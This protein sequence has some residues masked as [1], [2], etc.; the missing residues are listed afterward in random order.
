[1]KLQWL[2]RYKLVV[3]LCVIFL[4]ALALVEGAVPVYPGPEAGPAGI[5]GAATSERPRLF[6]PG[7]SVTVYANKLTSVETVLPYPYF[8][9][10]FCRPEKID[11]AQVFPGEQLLGTITQ[12]TI[13]NFQFKKDVDCAVPC[14]NTLKS[15]QL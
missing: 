14:K 9:A 13:Y 5:V 11:T 7:D 10:P 4:W 1:M 15:Q 6:K 8:Y 12:S 3:A 2:L